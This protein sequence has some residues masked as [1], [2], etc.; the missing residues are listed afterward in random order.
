MPK[1]ITMPMLMLMPTSTDGRHS[2]L[3]LDRNPSFVVVPASIRRNLFLLFSNSLHSL[4]FLSSEVVIW[5]YIETVDFSCVE[6]LDCTVKI[7]RYFS[8]NESA[9]WHDIDSISG[10]HW[11][12]CFKSDQMLPCVAP[13]S[14]ARMREFDGQGCVKSVWELLGPQWYHLQ[15]LRAWLTL[16]HC[17]GWR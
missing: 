17:I 2:S 5:N 11:L 10:Y 6:Q 14:L 16:V 7:V 9:S 8:P 13:V 4:E 12:W 1:P 3:Q 15:S